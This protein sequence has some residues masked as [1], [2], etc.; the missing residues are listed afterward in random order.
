MLIDVQI[1]QRIW[2]KNEEKMKNR[3]KWFIKRHRNMR[4]CKI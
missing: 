2:E 3:K 1:D 4:K